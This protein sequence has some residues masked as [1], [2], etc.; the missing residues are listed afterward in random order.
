MTAEGLSRRNEVQ[1]W[2]EAVLKS[3]LSASRWARGA[4]ISGSTITR[5]LDK[6]DEAALPKPETLRKLIQSAP[7][8]TARPPVSLLHMAGINPSGKHADIV[9]FEGVEHTMI[10]RFDAS[11]SAGLGSLLTDEPEPIG[12]HPIETQWLHSVTRAAPERL[13]IVKVDGDSMADTL[14]DGDWILLDLSQQRAS[15]EGIYALRVGQDLWV[16][17]LTLNL[18]DKLI[19]VISDNPRYPRQDLPEEDLEILGRVCWVVARRL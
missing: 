13:A 19:T 16:K 9:E 14:Q 12:H 8:D 7:D 15:R 1:A 10:P 11:V 6:P 5:F 2:Y 17:R 3:G 18:A 4:G